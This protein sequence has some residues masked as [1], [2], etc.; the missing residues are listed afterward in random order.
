MPRRE[1][2]RGERSIGEPS[3]VG[4]ITCSVEAAA[5]EEA[6]VEEDAAERGQ[7]EAEGIQPRK[8]HVSGADHQRHEIVRE[9]KH[10]R[11]GDEEDHRRAVHREHA[12]EELRR[13]EVVVRRDEL[14]SHDGRLEAADA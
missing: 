13:N 9:S 10:K 5:A 6:E 12:V 8:R 2:L 7:P 4:S 1:G 3:D 14:D 11:H